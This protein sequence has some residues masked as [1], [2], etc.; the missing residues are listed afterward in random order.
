MLNGLFCLNSL[1]WSNSNRRGV[2]LV[3]FV[4][5]FIKMPVFNANSVDPDQI[6]VMRRLIWA[7]TVCQ[8][9]FYGRLGIKGLTSMTC[10]TRELQT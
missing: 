6:R 7:Y 8:C 1:D 9:P 10:E 4:V 2:S 5:C 3:L